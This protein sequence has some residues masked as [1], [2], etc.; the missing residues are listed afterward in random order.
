MKSIIIYTTKYGSVEEA[1]KRL[2]K[3]LGGETE[4]CNLMRE[5]GPSLGAFDTVV[6]GGSVYIGRVQKRL[7]QF[8]SAHMRELLGKKV[9]LFLCAGEPKEDA[10]QKELENAFP[11]E[12]L[13]HAAAKDVLGYAVRFEKMNFFD[14]FIMKKVSGD[15]ADKEEYYDDRIATFA[16]VLNKDG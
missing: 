3:Q 2:Q 6:L 12:L 11:P 1:A 9:G 15:S 10:R 13:R 7:S 5:R 8:C 16:G 14:R 4:L